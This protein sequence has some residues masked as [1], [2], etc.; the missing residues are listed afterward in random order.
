MIT[1]LRRWSLD[2]AM[3]ALAAATIWLAALP[4]SPARALAIQ[5]IWGV[6]L[7]EYGVRL[8][9]APRKLDFVRGNLPDLLAILPWEMFRGARLFRLV[10]LLRFVRG[11]EVLWRVSATGRGVLRTNH[12]GHVLALTALLVLAGGVAI[13][14]IEPSV[15]SLPDG[16]WWSLVTTTTVGYGDIAP[17]TPEGRTIAAVLMLIGIGT[18]GMITGS[19]STYFL[20]SRGSSNPHIRHLQR[21]L[22]KWDEMTPRGKH[23]LSSI[24]EA[25]ARHEGG[26]ATNPPP[27]IA[28]LG[29]DRDQV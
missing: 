4:E 25:L 26:A 7:V 24:L 10:R 12:L 2:L 3:V 11:F 19:I 5:L 17:K 9:R 28:H 21:E 29:P 27:E 18:L 23:Q 15:G 16:V 14:H 6:F 8:L 13:T 22:D 1:W 20:G